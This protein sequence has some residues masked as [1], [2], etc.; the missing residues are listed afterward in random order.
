MGI[1]I[2][3][4]VAEALWTAA[5]LTAAAFRA[6]GVVTGVIDRRAVI[7]LK[8]NGAVRM[9]ANSR[10]RDELIGFVVNCLFA[11][12]GFY[13][14]TQPDPPHLTTGE[15]ILTSVFIAA[16]ILLAANAAWRSRERYA[17]REYL[18]RHPE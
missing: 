3:L 17:L 4:S 6:Y 7:Q 1:G 14:A 9:L 12:V 18:A 10:I 2:H 15:L 5:A 16:I 11:S 13:A 8:V